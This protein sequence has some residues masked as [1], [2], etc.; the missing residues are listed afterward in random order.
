MDHTRENSK[1]EPGVGW[2]EAVVST[3]PAKRSATADAGYPI[4]VVSRLTGIQ[5]STLRIWGLATLPA[6]SDRMR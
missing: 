4:G 6:E 5:P 1:S 2:Q 3:T